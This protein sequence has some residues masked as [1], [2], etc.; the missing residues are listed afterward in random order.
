M[1]VEFS[2]ENF[3]L[4]ETKYECK[5]LTEFSSSAKSNL[6]FYI[7]SQTWITRRMCSK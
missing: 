3:F 7:N 6:V 2:K 5:L 1:E 4:P